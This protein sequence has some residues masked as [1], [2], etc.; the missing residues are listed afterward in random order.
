MRPRSLGLPASARI[1]RRLSLSC[2]DAFLRSP[3]LGAWA[4]QAPRPERPCRHLR[5]SGLVR[6]AE[7]YWRNISVVA[8]LYRLTMRR[9]IGD[10]SSRYTTRATRVVG[11]TA[12]RKK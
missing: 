1:S 2:R 5:L 9:T 10:Q 4:F 11:P 8:D 12:A 3:L 6:V 7:V